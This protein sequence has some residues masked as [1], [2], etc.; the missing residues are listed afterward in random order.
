MICPILFRGGMYG[1]LLIGMLDQRSLI[2]KIYWKKDYGHSRCGDKYIKYTRTYLK[3]FFKYTDKKKIRYYESLKKL[4]H[5]V[6]FLTHDTDFSLNYKQ[7]T[8]QII[9]SD[10]TLFDHFAERFYNLH[11]KSVIDE[12]KKMITDKDNFGKNFIEIYKNSLISWQNTFKFNQQFDIK[13]IMNKKMFLEDLSVFFKLKNLT[14]AEYI[15]T[16]HFK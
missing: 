13:N 11:R 10:F 14:W 8:I 1:D 3:K 12:S 2:S 6:Y 15:Y 7:E 4:R 16:N 9:C 5:P